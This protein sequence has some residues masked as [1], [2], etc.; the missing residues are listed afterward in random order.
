MGCHLGHNSSFIPPLANITSM[1]AIV[2]KRHLG[3]NPCITFRSS[4]RHVTLCCRR[5]PGDA[6]MVS[7]RQETFS[8]GGMVVNSISIL[9]PR[10]EWKTE[11]SHLT[12]MASS[13]SWSNESKNESTS[14][15]FRDRYC[16]WT[17]LSLLHKL[18]V[19]WLCS[20]AMENYHRRRSSKLDT[21]K[22][23]GFFI[24]SSSVHLWSEN[25]LKSYLI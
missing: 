1:G 25:K 14:N 6:F 21:I 16:I 7:V 22:I 9:Y 18:K 5:T 3:M 12:E 2:S 17:V 13:A 10:S 8:P 11:T 4:M 15:D 20:A 19:E 24:W 23:S